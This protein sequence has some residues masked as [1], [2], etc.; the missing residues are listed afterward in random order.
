MREIGGIDPA[1]L[2]HFSARRSVIEAR[3]AELRADF[4]TRH[5]REPDPNTARE[6]AQQATLETREG[7]DRPRPLGEARRDWNAQAVARFGPAVI[8]QVAAT[9]AHRPAP[10]CGRRA[11]P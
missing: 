7:K 10:R 5:G 9:V 2:K 3:Y 1:V 11:Y 8:D 4:R 6:L